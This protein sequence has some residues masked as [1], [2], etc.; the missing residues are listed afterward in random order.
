MIAGEVFTLS[1]L[2]K[3]PEGIIDLYVVDETKAV[4]IA[5]LLLLSGD[6]Y[7]ARLYKPH[8]QGGTC[9]G[10]LYIASALLKNAD[11]VRPSPLVA[12]AIGLANEKT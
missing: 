6:F 7:S 3:K 1:M 10:D 12:A 9:I 11:D 5:I 4:E 2:Q 8:E